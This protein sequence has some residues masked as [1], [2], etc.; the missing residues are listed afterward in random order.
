MAQKPVTVY[1]L[2]QRKKTGHPITMV[3]AYDAPMARLLSESGID[4]AL[5]GDSLGNVVQGGENTLSVTLEEMLYHTRMVRRGLDGP[6]L[7]SDM[8]FLSYQVSLEEGHRNAGRL[9][10]E[11][12]AQAVK[13]EGGKEIAELV[14]RLTQSMIP[15]IGH[16]GMKPQGVHQMGGFRVQGRDLAGRKRIIE[17]A[18]ALLEAG[19]FALLLEA[20]PPSLAQEI[21]RFS[22]VPT[23][24]IGAGPDTDGQVLVFH[25]LVGWSSLPLPR[26]ARAF[27]DIGTHARS[28]LALF[29]EAV[30]NRTYPSSGESYP[31]E[32]PTETPNSR[33]KTKRKG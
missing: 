19:A 10:K 32:G 8:P 3:T 12:G 22:P 30:S 15:V 20:I 24:G 21:T 7:V 23:I 11:G 29:K 5:V 2:L 13:L 18:R 1:T 16:I 31:E 25:D 4:I 6:L 27:G 14:H 26:F 28:A 17:D 9:I 33:L